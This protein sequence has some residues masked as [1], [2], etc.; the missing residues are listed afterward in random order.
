MLRPTSGAIDLVERFA[1]GILLFP[2][3]M[4]DAMMWKDPHLELHKHV[5]PGTKEWWEMNAKL[6]PGAPAGAAGATA[7]PMAAGGTFT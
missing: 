6:Q 7:N 1:E 3:S 4:F 5:K 2:E